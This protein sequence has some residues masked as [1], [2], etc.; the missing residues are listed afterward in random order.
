MAVR[1]TGSGTEDRPLSLIEQTRRNQLIQVT[2]NLV[3]AHGYA[4]TSLARIAQAAGI[5]KGAVLYH[6]ASKD[7]VVA[8]A[9][10]HVLGTLVA[11]VGAAV[12]AAPVD[13]APTA[14]VRQMVRHLTERPDHIRVII[15]VMING[16]RPDSEARWR[17]L[18]AL[19][20]DAREARGLGPGTDPRTLAIIVGGAI[21]GIIS[22][23][24]RDTDYDAET[25]AETL[26]TMLEAATFA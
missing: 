14:Y 23:R 1:R 15:E 24:L 5:T 10:A 25:A 21:D 2:I 26:I 16:A 3:A 6:F 9:H 19:L 18:A 4:A 17:P 11:D 22:E 20:Q 8:A 13:Q 12:D 7:A